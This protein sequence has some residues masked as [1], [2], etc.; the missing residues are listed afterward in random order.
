[1]LKFVRIYVWLY[2]ESF[3]ILEYYFFKKP[4]KLLLSFKLR[5]Y[6]NTMEKVFV[7]D[8]ILFDT[9]FLKLSLI[10]DVYLNND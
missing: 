9:E 6:K 7:R 5:I 1:M 4:F 8:K 3:N 10:G 2:S